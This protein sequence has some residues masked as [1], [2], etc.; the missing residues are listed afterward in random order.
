MYKCGCSSL[1]AS[2]PPINRYVISCAPFP[3]INLHMWNMFTAA[4]DGAGKDEARRAVTF[5]RY[6]RSGGGGGGRGE[7]GGGDEG[8][9][10]WYQPETRVGTEWEGCSPFCIQP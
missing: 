9:G 1:P 8:G 3:H 4:I 7:R 5:I 10:E 2:L 6:F